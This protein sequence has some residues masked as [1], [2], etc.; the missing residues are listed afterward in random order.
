[1]EFILNTQAE[2]S[3]HLAKID[4]R[5]DG[6]TKLLKIGMRMLNRSNQNVSTLTGNVNTLTGNLSALTGKVGALTDAQLRTE[7]S[8]DKLSARLDA[9]ATAHADTESALQRFL[10]SMTK[11][12]NGHGKP[13]SE[14]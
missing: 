10:D 5:I 1:M 3:A 6:I 4:T 13:P 14:S 9:L 8:I 7:A 2:Q 12:R 11:G